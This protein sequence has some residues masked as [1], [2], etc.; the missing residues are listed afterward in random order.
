[1]K[2]TR[3]ATI[4]RSV[5]EWI[6][7]DNNDRPPKHVLLRILRRYNYL[8]H[9]SG[10]EIADG[11]RWQAE[12]IKPLW[13]GGENREANLAPAL[14]DPH[15]IKSRREAA[16]RAKADRQGIGA[17]GLKQRPSGLR[18]Q[19]HGFQKFE[20]ERRGVD[21]SEIAPLPRRNIFSTIPSR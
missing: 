13:A 3:I 17:A 19:S 11:M 21:K 8:C 6:G 1:M 10:R 16:Q 18:I 2:T 4:G 9:I 14:I 5:R 12:H 7:R 20:R 15:Q